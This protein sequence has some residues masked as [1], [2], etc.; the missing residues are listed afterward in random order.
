MWDSSLSIES[1]ERQN[2]L[3]CIAGRSAG[4]C[5][6][7][8]AVNCRNGAATRLSQSGAGA[9]SGHKIRVVRCALVMLP[10]DADE[11]VFSLARMPSLFSRRSAPRWI[12]ATR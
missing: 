2:P 4:T 7:L 6:L 1:L 9:L 5:R 10:P 3:P 8:M 12:S 11:M